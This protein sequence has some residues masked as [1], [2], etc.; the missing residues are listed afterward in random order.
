MRWRIMAWTFPCFP[1]SYR[2]TALSQT[3]LTFSKCYS[4]NGYRNTA[5]SQRPRSFSKCYFINKYNRNMSRFSGGQVD[6]KYGNSFKTKDNTHSE[7]NFRW[8]SLFSTR[9]TNP[10]YSSFSSTVPSRFSLCTNNRSPQINDGL[11]S[12]KPGTAR[13]KYCFETFLSFVFSILYRWMSLFIWISSTWS[14]FENL[15]WWF[16]AVRSPS[17]VLVKWPSRF[18][19]LAWIARALGASYDFSLNGNGMAGLKNK[20]YK[21][22]LKGFLNEK[23]VYPI[24]ILV[25]S[26][27]SKKGVLGFT[28]SYLVLEI[29]RFLT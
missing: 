15:V 23:I 27:M 6:S 8:T 17:I 5:F 9:C 4:I 14:M 16:N 11:F 24:L 28:A 29:F 1:H 22:W 7:Q 18:L 12:A 13:A 19:F 10:S 21:T 20:N 26:D 25:N 3:K 2:N